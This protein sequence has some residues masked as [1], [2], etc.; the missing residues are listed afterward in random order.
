MSGGM[1][2]WKELLHHVILSGLE[3]KTLFLC[4]I[5]GNKDTLRCKVLLSV[6]GMCCLANGMYINTLT[7]TNLQEIFMMG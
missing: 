3:L 1:R 7:D 4:C 2:K 6:K 5:P